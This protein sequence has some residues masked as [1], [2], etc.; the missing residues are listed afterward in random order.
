MHRFFCEKLNDSQAELLGAEAHHLL[1][2]HRL[3]AGDEVE[4]FDGN[5]TLAVGKVEKMSRQS[6]AVEIERLEKIEKPVEPQVVIAASIAK[7]ERFDWLI[8]KC[9]ELGVDAIYPVIFEHTVKQPANPKIVDR[10][11]NIAIQSVKQCKRLFLP[12]INKP[13]GLTEVVTAVKGDYQNIKILVASPN[14]LSQSI[15]K[16]EM[17]GNV[18]VFVGPEGGLSLNEDK[19]LLENGASFVRLTDTVLR[20]ETAAVCFASILCCKRA[21][22][23]EETM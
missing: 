18:V 3:K 22:V 14:A 1:H 23:R 16:V 6:V 15:E 4:L 2:V 20:I 17:K 7:G 19:F 5:G 8:A 9:T 12:K 11:N 10:W 13:L 21:A